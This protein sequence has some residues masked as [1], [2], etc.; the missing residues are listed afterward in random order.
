MNNNSFENKLR[1][2]LSKQGVNTLDVEFVMSLIRCGDLD[3]N[4]KIMEND[5]YS[6]L[7]ERNLKDQFEK[8]CESLNI[9]F[10]HFNEKEQ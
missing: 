8:A 3:E 6:K 7:E 5:V 10:T 2:Q 1:N 9:H 4:L